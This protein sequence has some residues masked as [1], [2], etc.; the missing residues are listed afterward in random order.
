LKQ[1]FE[2]AREAELRWIEKVKQL[3]I[4]EEEPDE[5]EEEFTIPDIPID[6]QKE[7]D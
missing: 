4:K 6:V 7:D 3:P 5:E 2:E 1:K